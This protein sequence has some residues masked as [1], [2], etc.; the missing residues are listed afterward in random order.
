M[1]YIRPRVELEDPIGRETAEAMELIKQPAGHVVLNKGLHPVAMV[2]RQRGKFRPMKLVTLFAMIR[3]GQLV[4]VYETSRR[5]VYSNR[6][7][8]PGVPFYASR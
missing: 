6:V 1:T 5:R 7:M 2:A 3:A 8:K 4:L